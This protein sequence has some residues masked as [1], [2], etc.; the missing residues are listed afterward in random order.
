MEP[1]TAGITAG[2]GL[3][4]SLMQRAAAKRAADQAL[5]TQEIGLNYQ[6]GNQRNALLEAMQN[7]Q[8][9]LTAQQQGQAD[10]LAAAKGGQA[11]RL[12]AAGELRYDQAG[13]ATYYDRDKGQWVT[14]Y[15]PQQER[16][17]RGEGA[18]QERTLARGAQASE[19]YAK[20]RA[21][22]LYDRPPTEAVIRDEIG[23]LLRTAQGTGERA[24]NTITNR[25]GTRTA[26][27][28]PTIQQ[29]D[30]GP[31]PSQ[32]LAD[33]MLKTRA[34][35]LGESQSRQQA[36]ANQ[37]L[38]A[39]AAFE[40]TANTGIQE[41]N[42]GRTAAAQ[43]SAGAGDR[44]SALA[45]YSK[46]LP[47]I[48]QSG[49]KDR[50]GVLESGGK[51]IGSAYDTG[52]KGV[53]SAFSGLGSAGNAATAAAGGGPRL[54]EFA[55]LINALKPGAT[56][57]GTKPTGTLG[58]TTGATYSGDEIAPFKAA[59]ATDPYGGSYFGASAPAPYSGSTGGTYDDPYRTIWGG[60]YSF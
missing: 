12:A 13:N 34:A 18:Q 58:G 30:R 56:K 55:S 36:H 23:R 40:K 53:A 25:W 31:T 19:D 27:N 8:A 46:M 50:L 37:Y 6:L 48:Y 41:G 57:A 5:R 43:R 44:A 51:L 45:D 21:G 32:E 22:Y 9:G 47:S 3:I 54:S 24:L 28:I 42:I 29:M 52:S 20:Q 1:L 33:T 2:A 11:D 39:L 38:P 26:G 10:T 17:R 15:T 49:T 4:N 35:A 7:M 14:V 60:D 16:L 59:N